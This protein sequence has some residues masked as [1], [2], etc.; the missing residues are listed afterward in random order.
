MTN[1]IETGCRAQFKSLNLSGICTK[2]RINAIMEHIS[3]WWIAICESS[4]G[5][6]NIKEKDVFMQILNDMNVFHPFQ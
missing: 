4:C 3:E 5:G 1:F 6:K 2:C